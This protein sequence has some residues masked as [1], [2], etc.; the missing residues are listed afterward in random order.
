[1]IVLDASVALKWFVD[2]EPLVDDAQA[3]L[4]RIQDDPRSYLCRICS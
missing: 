3:V 4:D 2:R 1:V